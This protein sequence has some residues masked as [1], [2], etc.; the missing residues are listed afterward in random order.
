MTDTSAPDAP[1]PTPPF[2]VKVRL[3]AA[4]RE[5]KGV[6]EVEVMV[7]VG[8]PVSDLFPLLFPEEVRTD[9]RWPGNLLYAINLNYVPADHPVCQGD[10]VALIP[11]LGGG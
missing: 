6:S 11:P 9:P 4:L 5:K 7:P 10:E 3:F 2:P 8:T 1:V